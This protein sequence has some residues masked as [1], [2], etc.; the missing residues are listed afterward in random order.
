MGV[1]VVKNLLVEITWC[2]EVDVDA[3]PRARTHVSLRVLTDQRVDGRHGDKVPA[4]GEETH[5]VGDLAE[6]REDDTSADVRILADEAVGH[7]RA[8]RMAQ[9]HDSLVGV[10][11]T[12]SVAAGELKCELLERRDL[13]EDLDLVDGLA[14]GGLADAETVPCEGRVA[15]VV[16]S[17]GDV[18]VLEV[19]CREVPVGTV[20]ADAVCHDLKDITRTRVWL[21]VGHC[22][23]VVTLDI[24]LLKREH[25]A[26]INYNSD[27]D[28]RGLDL[29][30]S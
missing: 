2:E 26:T 1:Q 9:V 16:D 21:T 30:Q 18:A 19:L 14:V 4:E 24:M 3:H 15:V 22:E 6:A 7:G 29:H 20:E 10:R 23:L 25:K 13:E 28:S 27:K 17:A 8:E 12:A 5:V 11:D